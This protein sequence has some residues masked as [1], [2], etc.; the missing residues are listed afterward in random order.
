MYFL[1]TL[2]DD[3]T[4]PLRR[5]EAELSIE[6]TDNYL[7]HHNDRPFVDDDGPMPIIRSAHSPIR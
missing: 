5:D 1:A 7:I 2:Q 3:V 4:T 6:D